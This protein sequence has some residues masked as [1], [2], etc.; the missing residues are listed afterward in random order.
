MFYAVFPLDPGTYK[1]LVYVLDGVRGNYD[2]NGVFVLDPQA[3]HMHT[4]EVK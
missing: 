4:Y 1:V 2:E 3:G